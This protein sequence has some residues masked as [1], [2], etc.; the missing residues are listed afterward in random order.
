VRAYIRVWR[1]VAAWAGACAGAILTL[2]SP[3]AAH[4]VSTGMGP[5]Y[6]GIGHLLLTPDDLV[7]ALALALFAGLR[8]PA[9]GRSVLFLL[10]AAWFAGGLAGLRAGATPAFPVPGL[11][12]L[13]VGA[14]IAADLRLPRAGVAALTA[15]LGLAHGYLNGAALAGGPGV[16]G[17]I[18]IATMLFVLAG[19]AAALVVS[20]R[21]PWARVAVRVAGSWASASGLL[22]IG[23]FVRGMR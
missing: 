5:V 22:M 7:A 21:Q 9:A 6:D 4:L 18:G 13:L 2:P 3:A 8:G 17:L 16:S 19:P 23:W 12:L 10:P 14:L 1:W 15:A 11:S 20:L